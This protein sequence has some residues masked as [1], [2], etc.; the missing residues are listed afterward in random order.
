MEE[1]LLHNQNVSY[2][3]FSEAKS[4]KLA[5]LNS[6][7]Q[8]KEGTFRALGMAGIEPMPSKSECDWTRG[9][10]FALTTWLRG[11]LKQSQCLKYCCY[12]A[13]Y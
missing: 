11:L 9:P 3:L 8:S 4:G 2:R 13:K 10:A 7:W 6:S 12:H 1:T 5:S